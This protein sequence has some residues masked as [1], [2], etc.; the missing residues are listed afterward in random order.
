[1]LSACSQEGEGEGP[2]GRK[3]HDVSPW[4]L[5]GACSARVNCLPGCNSF[6]TEERITAV[7][8]AQAASAECKVAS[9][10]PQGCRR[11][12]QQLLYHALRVWK[13]NPGGKCFW[14]G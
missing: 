7:A 2:Q 14:F 5:C 11:V 1:M 12:C 4:G 9:R 10:I 3:G 6:Q 8:P 13:V